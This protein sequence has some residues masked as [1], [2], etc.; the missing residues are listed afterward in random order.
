MSSSSSESDNDASNHEQDP[1]K[2]KVLEFEWL[3]NGQSP[4]PVEQLKSYLDYYTAYGI[5]I[6]E[7]KCVKQDGVDLYHPV[8]TRRGEDDDGKAFEYHVPFK[9]DL[10]ED[11]PSGEQDAHDREEHPESQLPM[12]C[13]SYAPLKFYHKGEVNRD[14]FPVH[15]NMCAELYALVQHKETEEKRKIRLAVVHLRRQNPVVCD[16]LLVCSV[17]AAIKV[18]TAA[19]AEMVYTPYKE[20]LKFAKAFAKGEPPVTKPA[21]KYY[22][23]YNECRHGPNGSI[24]ENLFS[25]SILSK[26]ATSIMS[27]SIARHMGFWFYPGQS[28]FSSFGQL[29]EGNHAADD[30]DD[31]MTDTVANKFRAALDE[32]F[33]PPSRPGERWLRPT[34]TV[35]EDV[36]VIDKNLW[37]V[38]KKLNGFQDVASKV[39]QETKE[40]TNRQRL[41]AVTKHIQ[42]VMKNGLPVSFRHETRRTVLKGAVEA[43]NAAQT[44]EASKHD[45]QTDVEAFVTF[46]A[47]A[48]MHFVLCPSVEVP[49][50]GKY[51]RQVLGKADTDDEDKLGKHQETLVTKMRTL[52][53][54]VVRI[55]TGEFGTVDMSVK[56]LKKALKRQ[57]TKAKKTELRRNANVDLILKV[58]AGSGGNGIRHE[59]VTFPMLMRLD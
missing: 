35:G 46:Q 43:F 57:K 21:E 29:G 14:S 39:G 3:K 52:H 41:T 28:H 7:R 56:K 11:A 53:E 40:F 5:S 23:R 15:D 4:K 9:V 19:G 2:V 42:P 1:T 18:K 37:F 31:K 10:G 59:G 47:Y 25:C 44:E 45:V 49:T 36:P 12:I 16:L 30:K 38:L 48:M 6:E 32:Y 50:R 34:Q 26:E 24:A 55:E 58:I 13:N 27:A 20:I 8:F 54:A 33:N 17:S 22:V 51:F